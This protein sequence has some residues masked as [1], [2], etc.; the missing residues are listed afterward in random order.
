MSICLQ[1]KE[2]GHDGAHNTT[3]GVQASH[4][5]TGAGRRGGAG[6]SSSRLRR[7]GSSGSSGLGL[8]LSG[9]RLGGSGLVAGTLGLSSGTRRLRGALAGGAGTGAVAGFVAGNLIGNGD[10]G[11]GTDLLGVLDSSGLTRSITLVLQAAGDAVE[12]IVIAADALDVKLTAAGDAVSGGVL[13][14]TRGRAA[15]DLIRLSGSETSDQGKRED[16]GLHGDWWS[17]REPR[18]IGGKKN[19]QERWELEDQMRMRSRECRMSE[20][21][22]ESLAEGKGEVLIAL[23]IGFQPEWSRPVTRRN[24]GAV[25]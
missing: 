2:K 13:V 17:N 4:G 25:S 14:D 12:E 23:Q 5:G 19:K 10:A 9:G 18:W 15:R 11:R 21:G 8:G 6:R 3:S 20:E 7:L 16:G 24:V 1:R 22:S